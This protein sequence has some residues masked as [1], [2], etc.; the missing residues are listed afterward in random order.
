MTS[1][2]T[3][4]PAAANRSAT[5][6]GT[7][8]RRNASAL[9]NCWSRSTRSSVPTD[10]SRRSRGARR[11]CCL[12]SS[13][14]CVPGL[15][16]LWTNSYFVA[17]TG[18]TVREALRTAGR[19]ALDALQVA[20]DVIILDGGD[21]YL[22]D[23]TDQTVNPPARTEVKGDAR[24]AVVSAASVLAKSHRDRLMARLAD[25]YPGCGWERNAGYPGAPEH[26]AGYMVHGL[27]VHHRRSWGV[28][29]DAPSRLDAGLARGHAN[30]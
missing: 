20:P 2:K 17:T 9:T 1:K 13:R 25:Q 26:L 21:N 12:R 29:R 22:T 11:G 15:P 8:T 4:S 27:S 24:C 19:R 7:P 23:P 28:P 10:W 5:C 18:L 3:D 6:S 14:R 30:R 16:T